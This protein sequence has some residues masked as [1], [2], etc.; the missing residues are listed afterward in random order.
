MGIKET[1]TNGILFYGPNLHVGKQGKLK[2][3][4]AMWPLHF[5]N[6]TVLQSRQWWVKTK[7]NIKERE[8]WE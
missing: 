3:W 6:I 7:A 1:N 8:L 5:K 2:E 4:E